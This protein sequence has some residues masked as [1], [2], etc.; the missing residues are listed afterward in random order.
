MKL[1]FRLAIL[2]A[3]VAGTGLWFSAVHTDRPGHLACPL[4]GKA[5]CRDPDCVVGALERTGRHW[6]AE[7][8]A[9]R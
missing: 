1:I 6:G 4:T 3:A 8:T 2:V 9:R 7:L 5:E